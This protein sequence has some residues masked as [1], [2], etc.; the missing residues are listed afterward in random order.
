MMYKSRSRFPK[1]THFLDSLEHGHPAHCYPD[2]SFFLRE[3]EFLLSLEQQVGFDGKIKEL[4]SLHGA[5]RIGQNVQW[6]SLRAEL[7]AI[8]VVGSELK[9]P[10]NGFE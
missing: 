1:A 5:N 2:N 7:G 8:Y 6:F 9:L 4:T 3:I 10:I